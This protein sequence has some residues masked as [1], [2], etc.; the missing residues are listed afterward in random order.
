MNYS[1][2][3]SSQPSP[4]ESAASLYSPGSLTLM[5]KA[6][7]SLRPAWWGLPPEPV[8]AWWAVNSG[9]LRADCFL[10][11]GFPGFYYF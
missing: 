9:Y 1:L 7:G 11:C 5:S 8:L 6:G 2:G 3:F 4:V 10:A